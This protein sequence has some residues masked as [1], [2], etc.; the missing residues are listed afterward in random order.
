MLMRVHQSEDQ[1]NG[2]N[3]SSI[4][5]PQD[6]RWKR[7]GNGSTRGQLAFECEQYAKAK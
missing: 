4:D 6:V 5:S 1:K 2:R 3:Y 7:N